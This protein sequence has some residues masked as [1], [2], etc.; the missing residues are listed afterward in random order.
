MRPATLAQIRQ[1]IGLGDLPDA[2]A[3][4]LG[5]GARGRFVVSIAP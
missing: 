5:G 4:L 3:T 1:V 2:F